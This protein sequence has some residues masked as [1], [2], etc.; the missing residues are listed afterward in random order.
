MEWTAS[1]FN[2]APALANAGIS[3]AMGRRGADVAREAA[4]GP[5]ILNRT[6]ERTRV[7]CG[8]KAHDIIA[9]AR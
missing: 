3:I 1:G 5:S 6:L 7:C 4:R 2:D 8:P 9:D